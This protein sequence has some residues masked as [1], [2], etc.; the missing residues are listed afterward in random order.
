MSKKFHY[1]LLLFA[2]LCVQGIMAQGNPV[3]GT[4]TDD[5]G[6]P[7]PGVNVVQKGTTNGTSTDFDGNFSINVPSTT[8]LVFSSLGFT[9]KEIAVGGQSTINVSLSEDAEQLGEVVVTA[10]GIKRERKS[11]GYALQEIKGGDI[12]ESRESNVTNA[13]SG[14]VAGLQVVK[15]SNGPASSSKIVLRGNNSLTGDNQPLIV[16][17]GVPMDNFTGSNNNDFW[18]PAADMGNGLG[19]LNPDNIES[20]SVLKGASA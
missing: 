16:V 1:F 15:G 4:V 5:L 19:D 20:M 18:N 9:T 11:L 8:T 13:L 2:F 12:V 10:L 17:D 3:T 7:L 6:A 14:K